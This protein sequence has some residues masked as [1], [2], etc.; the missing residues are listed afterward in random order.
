ML[1]LMNQELIPEDFTSFLVYLR[2]FSCINVIKSMVNLKIGG[3]KPFLVY[4][5]QPTLFY[6]KQTT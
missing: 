2:S 4:M 3:I 1:N 5:F 6:H